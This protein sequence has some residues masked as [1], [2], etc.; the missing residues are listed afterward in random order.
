MKKLLSVVLVLLVMF[1]WAVADYEDEE[2]FD[3]DAFLATEEI[4]LTEGITVDCS[5]LTRDEAIR[6]SLDS[7][8][9]SYCIVADFDSSDPEVIMVD[10]TMEVLVTENALSEA[11]K[12]CIR[13]CRDL[14]VREDIPMIRFCY[15]EPAVGG[16]TMCTITIRLEKETAS[17]IDLD[18]Y[19]KWTANNQ[20]EFLRQVDGYSLHRDYK[21]VAQ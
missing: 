9:S 4:E 15:W 20:L 11:I 5:S 13:V 14:F 7:H 18:Y 3:L 12:Y 21:R 19:E 1:S 6:M 16:G 17:R 8:Y 10:V 2:Y